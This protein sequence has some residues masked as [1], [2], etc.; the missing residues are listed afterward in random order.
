MYEGKDINWIYN[1]I[2]NRHDK[3]R[4]V[5]K[6]ILGKV[7]GL[8]EA[9]PET[10]VQQTR[11]IY[12]TAEDIKKMRQTKT[13]HPGCGNEKPVDMVEFALEAGGPCEWQ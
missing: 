4:W 11:Q 1:E 13:I 2:R 9:A 5:E 7:M 8:F 3:A 12:I 10:K 6:R